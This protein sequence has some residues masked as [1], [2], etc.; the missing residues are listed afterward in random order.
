M[1]ATT[2]D[3]LLNPELFFREKKAE[4]V[5]LRV[6]ALIVLVWGILGAIGAFISVGPVIQLL[7]SE[8]ASFSPIVGVIAAVSAL[9]VSFIMWAAWAVVFFLVSLVFKGTG[10]FKRVLEFVAYGFIPQII[11]SFIAIPLMYSYLSGV[12]LPPVSD[13]AL[14]QEVIQEVM[15]A[16]MMLLAIGIGLLF[17]LWSANIWIFGMK[18][19]R[20]LSSRDALITVG[21]PVGLYLLS[22]VW[23]LVTAGGV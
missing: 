1:A 9:I 18:E 4:E 23:N 11:G 15:T 5:S 2:K 6:P 20:N 8:A 22:Q 14:I 19:A 21:V 3:V 13:P 10:E 12:S 16:P 7:P 17:L